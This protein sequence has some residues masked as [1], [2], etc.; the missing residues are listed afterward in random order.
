MDV[1]RLKKNDILQGKYD[2][3]FGCPEAEGLALRIIECVATVVEPNGGTWS[4]S[5]WC[6]QIWNH[7]RVSCKVVDEAHDTVVN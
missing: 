6:M 5:S 1:I 3:L 4:L 7:H 2:F